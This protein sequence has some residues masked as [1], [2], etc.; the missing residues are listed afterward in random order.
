VQVLTPY[1]LSHR[2]RLAAAAASPPPK[3]LRGAPGGGG[4]QQQQQQQQQELVPDP[5]A[6]ASDAISPSPSSRAAI[7]Q[8]RLEGS[9]MAALLDTALLLA[10]LAAPDSGALLRFVQRPN[11]VDLEAGEAALRSAGRYS[12]LVALY[13]SKGRHSA[14]LN[15]LHNLSQQPEQLPAPAQGASAG[16]RWAGRFG[17]PVRAGDAPVCSDQHCNHSAQMRWAVSSCS[18]LLTQ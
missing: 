16:E 10:L 15:L 17:S 9:A 13:Q 1:L 3:P 5:L 6:A 4:A 2:S 12:E 11:W 8:Q 14:A 18:L 7:V